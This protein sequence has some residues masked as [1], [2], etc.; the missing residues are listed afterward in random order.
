MRNL[1]YS[2]FLRYTPVGP[3]RPDGGDFNFVCYVCTLPVILSV[4]LLGSAKG[5]IRRIFATQ[6]QSII[7]GGVTREL[8]RYAD[9]IMHLRCKDSSHFLLGSPTKLLL[10]RMTPHPPLSR[11]P[12]PH[13]GRLFVRPES[14]ST[15]PDKHCFCGHKSK[16]I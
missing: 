8:P 15:F 12:F 6:W 14:P 10:L 13:W 16:N 1:W 4:Q 7:L 2:A 5:S 9:K 11:S 3:F